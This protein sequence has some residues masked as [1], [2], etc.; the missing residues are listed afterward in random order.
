MCIRDGSARGHQNAGVGYV[1]P[2]AH[3]CR[4]S[5]GNPSVADEGA[6]SLPFRCSGR[7]LRGEIGGILDG[8]F[9]PSAAAISTARR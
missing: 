3:K 5:R 7:A 8:D 9:V 4:L 1:S 6:G 2:V